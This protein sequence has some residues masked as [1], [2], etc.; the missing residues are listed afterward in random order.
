MKQLWEYNVEELAERCALAENTI[1]RL[2]ADFNDCN[3]E[4]ARWRQE[5]ERLRKE[6]E[7]LSQQSAKN[8]LS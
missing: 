6:L 7:C 2:L 3:I 1:D 4:R 8:T 5:A